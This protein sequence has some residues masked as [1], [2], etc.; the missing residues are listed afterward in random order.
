MNRFDCQEN[1]ALFQII[2]MSPG[3]DTSLRRPGHRIRQR[4]ELCARS[5]DAVRL[6][7]RLAVAGSLYHSAESLSRMRRTLDSA[8]VR[9]GKCAG[10]FCK[11]YSCSSPVS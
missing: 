1:S 10:R 3:T 4:Y 8:S 9:R 6:S 7:L 2:F 11:S 5:F